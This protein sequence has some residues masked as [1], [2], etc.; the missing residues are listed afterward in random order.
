MRLVLPKSTPL[1]VAER[2]NRAPES[3]KQQLIAELDVDR[4]IEAERAATT[5]EAARLLDDI[6]DFEHRTYLADR[7]EKRHG[8]PY[9]KAVQTTDA[10]GRARETLQPTNYVASLKEER[11]ALRSERRKL[12]DR[13]YPKRWGRFCLEQLDEHR[14]A[15]LVAD[16]SPVTPDI[17]PGEH[18]LDAYRRS[19]SKVGTLE[20]Q[21]HDTTAAPITAEEGIEFAMKRIDAIATPP[22]CGGF[23]R[24]S[25]SDTRDNVVLGPMRNCDFAWPSLGFGNGVDVP[26]VVRIVAWAMKPHL[27]E[28]VAAEMRANWSRPNAIPL[29]EKRVLVPKLEAEL[30]QAHRECN[31][32]FLACRAQGIAVN[33]PRETRV[34][35]ILGLVRFD[36]ARNAK[37]ANDPTPDTGDDFEDHD[38]EGDDN[39]FTEA[40]E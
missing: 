18:V 39:E 8:K 12:L 4:K 34:E 25:Y 37:P 32:L 16:D 23:I 29:A 13:K 20:K 2:L 10:D 17:Q 33:R 28:L 11:D 22:G 36:I 14:D 21:L 26:D 38:F 24:G 9:S 6:N 27:K 1:H 35:C 7:E 5:A 40:A 31:A 19:F 15:I 3:A 30:W